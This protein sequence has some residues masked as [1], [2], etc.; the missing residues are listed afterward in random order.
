VSSNKKFEDSISDILDRIDDGKSTVASIL[1][2]FFETA[3]LLS[4][5]DDEKGRKHAIIESYLEDLAVPDGDDMPPGYITRLVMR[6]AVGKI[7]GEGS[8]AYRKA[9]PQVITQSELEKGVAVCSGCGKN[10][11][12]PQK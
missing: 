9:A 12:F 8:R 2:D 10:L 5:T 7:A 11:L 1:A 6:R 3:A 4:D